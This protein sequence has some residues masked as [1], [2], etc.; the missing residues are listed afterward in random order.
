MKR[1]AA[2]KKVRHLTKKTQ[3]FGEVTTVRLDSNVADGKLRWWNVTMLDYF[4]SSAVSFS[5]SAPAG[6]SK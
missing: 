4:F 6:A 5:A 3:T 2:R 1:F